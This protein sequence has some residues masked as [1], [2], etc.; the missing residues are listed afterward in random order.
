[1]MLDHLTH[2]RVIGGVGPG[3]LPSDSSM[4]GLTPTDTRELLETNLDIV[5]RLLAGETVSR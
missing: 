3:S 4:I 2:G 1:M 5:V